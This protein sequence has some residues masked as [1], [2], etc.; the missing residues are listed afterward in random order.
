MNRIRYL[1]VVPLLLGPATNAVEA[2]QDHKVEQAPAIIESKATP[3]SAASETRAREYFTDLPV[4]AQDGSKLRF[5]TDVL[6]D[7]IVLIVDPGLQVARA[8][9]HRVDVRGRVEVV[10]EVQDLHSCAPSAP[11]GEGRRFRIQR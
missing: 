4:I 6:K 5:Y 10:V 2:H 8:L 11:P 7:R 3:P 1:L 9:L